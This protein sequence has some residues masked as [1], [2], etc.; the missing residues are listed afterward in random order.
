MPHQ[1][2]DGDELTYREAIIIVVAVAAFFGLLYL[3]VQ[4]FNQLR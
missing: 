4:S 3:A 1:P 2:N